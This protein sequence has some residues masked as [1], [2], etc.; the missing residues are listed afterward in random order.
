MSLSA[1]D[2]YRDFPA[3]T[4][5]EFRCPEVSTSGT[6]VAHA[7]PLFGVLVSDQDTGPDDQRRV[8]ELAC[9]RCKQRRNRAGENVLRVI[10]R[11][12]MDGVLVETLVEPVR[13][14]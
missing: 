4:R 10:H 11:F 7:G 8:M 13:L 5:V 9:Q 12:Q 3:G 14:V 2:G 6:G 1:S